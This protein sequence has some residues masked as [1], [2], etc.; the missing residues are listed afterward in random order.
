MNLTKKII[1]TGYAE[2]GKDTA[3]EYLYK[4]FG[5]T[6]ESSSH[7]ACELFLF[8]DL[9]KEHGYK[10]FDECYEDRRNHRKL[11]ADKISEFNR[12]NGLDALGK[13]IFE[14]VDCYNG[15]RKLAELNALKSS[16]LVDL[17]IWLDASERMPPESIESMDIPPNVADITISNNGS[18]DELKVRLNELGEYLL[19]L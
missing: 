18:I 9:K 12:I 2:H 10:T 15:I 3:C 7:T 8:D 13:V 16:G 6:F 14:R 19:S 11:W 5:I 4:K 17:V 1:I